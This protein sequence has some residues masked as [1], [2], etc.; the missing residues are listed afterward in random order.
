MREDGVRS[1]RKFIGAGLDE[2][3]ERVDRRHVGGE[4]DLDLEFVGLFRKDEPRLEVALRVLLP[5]DEVFLRRD[6]QRVIENRRPAMDGGTQTHDR[7]PKRN[8]LGVLIM[9]DVGKNTKSV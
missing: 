3:I 2:K 4:L 9:G 1:E 8:R 5:V 6:L 7:R